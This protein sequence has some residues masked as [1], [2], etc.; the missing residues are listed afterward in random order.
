MLVAEN[1][2]PENLECVPVTNQF[3]CIQG[4]EKAGDDGVS[5]GDLH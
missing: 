4:P 3:P 1:V 2:I 5:N